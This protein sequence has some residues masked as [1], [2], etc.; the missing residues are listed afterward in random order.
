M[1]SADLLE[2]ELKAEA[3]E[4]EEENEDVFIEPEVITVSKKAAI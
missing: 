2:E 1:I 3:E 4:E